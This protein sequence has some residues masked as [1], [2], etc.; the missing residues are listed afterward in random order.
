MFHHHSFTFTV[1]YIIGSTSFTYYIYMFIPLSKKSSYMQI[2]IFLPFF[3][4]FYLFVYLY[5]EK[6]TECSIL[7]KLTLCFISLRFRHK[8]L[9]LKFLRKVEVFHIWKFNIK[10][11]KNRK[12]FHAYCFV[13]IVQSVLV[14]LYNILN[15]CKEIEK[16][17][18]KPAL[19]WLM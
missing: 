8:F 18:K 19:L 17:N 7:N 11:K 13:C 15:F 12:S 4:T 9:N 10:K 14:L 16:R 5:I 3:P 1:C 6:I 2:H